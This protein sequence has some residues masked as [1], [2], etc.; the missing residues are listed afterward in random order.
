MLEDGDGCARRGGSRF[1]TADAFTSE[2]TLGQRGAGGGIGSD[3]G[4]AAEAVGAPDTGGAT[5]DEGVAVSCDGAVTVRVEASRAHAATVMA[6][7]A[8]I[9]FTASVQP[10]V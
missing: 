7:T 3:W 6:A 2:P 5:D 1:T 8:T 9:A 4:V 10:P